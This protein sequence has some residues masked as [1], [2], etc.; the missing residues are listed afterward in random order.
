MHQFI[1][2]IIA[3]VIIAVAVYFI[4]SSN[5]SVPSGYNP[6]TTSTINPST[7]T[8]NNPTTTIQPATSTI[9]NPTT[10]LGGTISGNFQEVAENAV[11]QELNAATQNISNSD[12]ENSIAP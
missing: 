8:P 2:A 7:Q 6:T 1:I 12:I 9:S 5:M 11:D 3:I 10:T 4:R